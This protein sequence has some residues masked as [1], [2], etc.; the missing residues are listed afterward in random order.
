V[1]EENLWRFYHQQ[2]LPKKAVEPS[3]DDCHCK[4]CEAT[5]HANEPSEDE[6]DLPFEDDDFVMEDAI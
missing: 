4:N 2:N 6:E 5:R 1:R 3:I